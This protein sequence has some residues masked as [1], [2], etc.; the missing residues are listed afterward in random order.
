MSICTLIVHILISSVAPSVMIN[1]KSTHS[2][3]EIT[4]FK[5]LTDSIK[6][7]KNKLKSGI[8]I[9]KNSSLNLNTGL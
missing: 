4:T 2:Q 8:L 3:R 5:S 7:L 9:P 6:S 1:N